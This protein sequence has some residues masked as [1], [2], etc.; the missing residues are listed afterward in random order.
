[1]GDFAAQEGDVLHARQAG[2]RHERA[3]AEKM[4]GILL[5]QTGSRRSNPLLVSGHAAD[6]LFQPLAPS[7][8][9]FECFNLHRPTSFQEG[10]R[11]SS[12]ADPSSIWR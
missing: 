5:A 2:C 1:M 12:R 3:R 8:Q 10:G 4:P 11:L 9:R 7:R 6:L